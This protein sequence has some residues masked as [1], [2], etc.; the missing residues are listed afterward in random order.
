MRKP[1]RVLFVCRAASSESVR[2]AQALQSLE[3]IEVTVAHLSDRDEIVAA[4]VEQKSSQIVT[5]QETL[6]EAVALANEQLGLPGM[7]SATVRGTLNKS[8]LKATLKRAGINTPRYQL[9]TDPSAAR[10]FIAQIGF[11]IVLKSP[12]GSGALATL[13]IHTEADLH[14]ALELTD[15]PLLAEQYIA[16]QELSIDTFTLN[17]EPQFHSICCYQP[18]ILEAVEQPEVQWRCVMPRE[19]DAYQAFIEQG[20]Q[21][22]KALSVGNAM[23]HMEGFLDSD[24]QPWFTDAT[25]RPAGARIAPMLAFAYDIDPYR[26]WARVVVDGCFDGPWERKYAVGTV[27]LRGRGSGTVA[28]I[29]GMETLPAE[30]NYLIVEQRLPQIHAQ[31]SIAYT[32]D[33]FITIRHESTNVVHDALTTIAQSIR[34]T[35]SSDSQPAADWRQRLHNYNELNR[36]AWD[37]QT[38]RQDQLS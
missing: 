34:I 15:S 4:A 28:G 14:R 1:R 21:A 31:K 25:L 36:P 16:G 30:I 18:S 38:E 7:S 6:L 2:V 29:E 5:A 12:I 33:G 19:L 9:I 35:Y 24:G 11:P 26:A 17:G 32:G 23:T 20:R 22:I 37:H 10:D 3:N 13:L 8:E 27:F